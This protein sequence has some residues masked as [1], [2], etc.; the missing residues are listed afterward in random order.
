MGVVTTGLCLAVPA[1][2]LLWFWGRP[3]LS[4]RWKTPGWFVATAGLS[5][6][7]TA[8]TW[9]VGAFAGSSMSSAES[10]RQAGVNYDSAYRAAHWRES[11][12]WFPLHDRCNA[13]HDLVPAWINPTLVLLTVL[14]VLSVGVA[15]WLAVARHRTTADRVP[16]RRSWTLSVRR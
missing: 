14:A 4:G 8:V 3:L 7:A 1:L 12:R 13:T 5:I 16:A 10:C 15:L 2:F 6:V 9:F 11:S